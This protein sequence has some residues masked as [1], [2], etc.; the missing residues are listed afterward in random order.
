[1]KDKIQVRIESGDDP[2][3]IYEKFAKQLAKLGIKVEDDG[4]EH[5][6][7]ILINIA[8]TPEKDV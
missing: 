3:L 7:Y 8:P 2:Y 4:E 5:E 1:M 6:G